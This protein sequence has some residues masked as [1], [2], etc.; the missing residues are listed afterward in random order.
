MRTVGPGGP[1]LGA[2]RVR[3]PAGAVTT[4]APVSLPGPVR[5]RSAPGGECVSVVTETAVRAG[6]D[7]GLAPSNQ[8]GHGR[9]VRQYFNLVVRQLGEGETSGDFG[10]AVERAVVLAGPELDD[11]EAGVPDRNPPEVTRA[12]I[13]F[14]RTRLAARRPL[15][16]RTAV[17]AL[18]TSAPFG[19]APAGGGVLRLLIALGLEHGAR[20]AARA[21]IDSRLTAP[22][23]QAGGSA[24]GVELALGRLP[25]LPARPASRTSLDGRML[26]AAYAPARATTFLQAL[27]ASI[28]PV[29]APIVGV[30]AAVEPARRPGLGI[31]GALG[32]ASFVGARLAPAAVRL[33]RSLP[34]LRA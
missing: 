11:G 6:A 32:G 31:A 13:R 14:A 22:D 28:A 10:L 26:A 16:W 23:A 5:R 9:D 15:R 27:A 29:P 8:V 19:I 18:S 21:A 2:R 12:L 17:G 3:L 33:A 24:R 25:R 4:A 34:A 1:F 7:A 30:A 20:A